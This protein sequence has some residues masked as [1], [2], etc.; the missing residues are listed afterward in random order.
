MQVKGPEAPASLVVGGSLS[1]VMV[2]R[3]SRIFSSGSAFVSRLDRESYR[4][5]HQINFSVCR[6]ITEISP[7]QIIL[8]V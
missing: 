5:C 8:W 3:V 7:T 4:P 2:K 1:L 6:E